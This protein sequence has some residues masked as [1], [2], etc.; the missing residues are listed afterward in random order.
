MSDPMSLDTARRRA[1]LAAILGLDAG[2]ITVQEIGTQLMQE[3]V[4]VDVALSRWRAR[5]SLDLDDLGLPPLDGTEAEAIRSIFKLGEKRLL[6]DSY[7]KRLAAHERTI[8][9]TLER[10]SFP[11][12]WGSFVPATAFPAWKAAHAQAEAAYLALRDELV[13]DHPQIL[14]LLREQY[15]VASRRAYRVLH[16]MEGVLDAERLAAQEAFVAATWARIRASVPPATE[17]GQSFT[18]DVRYSLVPLPSLL[19]QGAGTAST[20]TVAGLR[21]RVSAAEEAEAQRTRLIAEMNREVLAQARATK[22]AL[23]DGFLAGLVG[24]LRG[25]IYQVSAD[26]LDALHGK[27]ALH[28]R[29][30]GSL[31]TLISTVERLNF[32]GDAEATAMIA[33][34]Q[35]LLDQAPEARTPEELGRVLRA[36]GTVA[37]S[38]LIALGETPRSARAVGIADVPSTSDIRAARADLGLPVR[39]G[40]ELRAGRTLELAVE[41]GRFDA[42]TRRERRLEP[43]DDTLLREAGEPLRLRRA[44]I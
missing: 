23:I 38:S 12:P 22:E 26:V 6:P 9:R 24:Q 16:R 27:D 31:K 19:A 3:G 29:S 2:T 37:R 41:H 14:A 30:L 10:F 13:R 32:F 40:G 34:V 20:A 5:T 25:L 21:A 42:P 15:A 18:L 36:V 4:I 43:T 11:S 7:F 44:A 17:I 28:N 8:Y 33:Q 1:T 35:G 39:E